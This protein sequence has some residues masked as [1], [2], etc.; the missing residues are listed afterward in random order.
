MWFI[1]FPTLVIVLAAAILSAV[2]N[3]FGIDLVEAYL[4]GYDTGLYSVILFSGVWQLCR[5]RFS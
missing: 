1:D 2:A 5:Q 4:P 3:L